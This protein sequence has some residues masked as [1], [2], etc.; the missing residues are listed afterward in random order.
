M[1]VLCLVRRR[2]CQPTSVQQRDPRPRQLPRNDFGGANRTDGS[3]LN[4]HC[5]GTQFNPGSRGA[6]L[7]APL[8]VTAVSWV[9][10][11]A[12]VAVPRHR[13]IRCGD[14]EKAGKQ[15]GQGYEPVR[16]LLPA[17]PPCVTW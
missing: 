15:G 16:P 7:S 6:F 10:V 1:D 9:G 17:Y 3:I 5:M 12:M 11:L 4:M 13:R 8:L 14:C 2:V